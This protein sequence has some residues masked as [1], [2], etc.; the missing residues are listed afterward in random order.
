MISAVVGF[1]RGFVNEIFTIIGWFAAVIA[2]L[3]LTPVFRDFGRGFFDNKIIADLVTASVI[4]IVTLGICSLISYF[5]SQS[6]RES[7]LNAVD[8]SLGFGFGLIRAMI[9]L[10][11]AYVMVAYVWEVDDRPSWITQAHTH[12]VL[13]TAGSMMNAI[14][15]GDLDIQIRE[16]DEPS[17]LDRVM[18]GEKEKIDLPKIENQKGYSDEARDAIGDFFD[19]QR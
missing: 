3:F 16:E 7:S 8:R 13:E 10:G 17:A 4:F 9:L 15:P 6:L 18:A 1:I 19:E 5:T 14:L 2:T 12:P 11:L